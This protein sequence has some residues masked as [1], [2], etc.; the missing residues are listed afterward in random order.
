[1]ADVEHPLFLKSLEP[2]PFK[3]RI[4]LKFTAL[5]NYRYNPLCSFP[6]TV[7]TDFV[8]TFTGEM[9]CKETPCNKWFLILIKKNCFRTVLEIWNHLKYVYCLPL[10]TIQKKFVQSCGKRLFLNCMLPIHLNCNHQIIDIPSPLILASIRD[11][12]KCCET[13]WQI[14]GYKSFFAPIKRFWMSWKYV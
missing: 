1:M 5:V 14:F 12:Q 3:E 8:F 7:H 6:L 10:N 2:P 11:L 9:L 4:L 13:I